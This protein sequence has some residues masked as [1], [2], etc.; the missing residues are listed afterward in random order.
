M[1][2][3]IFDDQYVGCDLGGELAAGFF[4]KVAQRRCVDIEHLGSIILG[5]SL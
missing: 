5:Q 4:D 3:F 2:V 1:N